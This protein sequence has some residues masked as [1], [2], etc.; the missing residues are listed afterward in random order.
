M[1][2]TYLLRRAVSAY[3]SKGDIAPLVCLRSLFIG[4]GKCERYAQV[5][6]KKRNVCILQS[7]RSERIDLTMP[8]AN[9]FAKAA[10]LF[11]VL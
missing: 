2:Y 7:E 3:Y 8:D 11:I 5:K 4:R 1:P 10:G 9:H 6:L